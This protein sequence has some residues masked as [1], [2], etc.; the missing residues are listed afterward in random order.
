MPDSMSRTKQAADVIS[1]AVDW[2]DG[3]EALQY[4]AGPTVTARET[5]TLRAVTFYCGDDVRVQA[6]I[7]SEGRV[8]MVWIEVPDPL[9][10][11]DEW[12]TVPLANV[13]EAAALGGWASAVFAAE[14]GAATAS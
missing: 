1:K 8:V 4:A 9:T 7:D 6:R 3:S 5:E 13:T 11:G 2:A 10:Y 14:Q 12:V